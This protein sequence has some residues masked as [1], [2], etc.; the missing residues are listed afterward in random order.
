MAGDDQPNLS[1]LRRLAARLE[2][3]GGR[4][5]RQRALASRTGCRNPKLPAPPVSLLP[6]RVGLPS[7]T[8]TVRYRRLSVLSKMAVSDRSLPTL[9]TTAKRQ[10]EVRLAD[11]VRQCRSACPGANRLCCAA[12]LAVLQAGH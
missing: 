9:G 3:C 2:R 4:G 1:L 5:G 10:A 6:R 12:A 11:P 8:V 7:P